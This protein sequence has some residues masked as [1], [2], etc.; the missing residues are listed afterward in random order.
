MAYDV[1]RVAEC[2][3]R[4]NTE[5]YAG[6]KKE[7][8]FPFMPCF[9]LCSRKFGPFDSS[10][11]WPLIDTSLLNIEQCRYFSPPGAQTPTG[12][13][14]TPTGVFFVFGLGS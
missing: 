10:N 3:Q 6:L 2:V 14:Q 12:I 7:Y 11:F 8:P 5:Q 4:N 9:W 13:Q 1:G